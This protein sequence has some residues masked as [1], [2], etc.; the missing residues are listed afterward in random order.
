MKNSTPMKIT[1]EDELE[2][3]KATNCYLCGCNFKQNDKKSKRPLSYNWK[4]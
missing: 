4:V 1:D 3:Q 2:F